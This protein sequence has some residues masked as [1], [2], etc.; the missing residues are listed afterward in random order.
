VKAS[1]A[2]RAT[3]SGS[4]AI[5]Y[6]NDSQPRI[7][8]GDGAGNIYAFDQTDAFPAPI[9]QAALGGPVDGPPI[10]AN[11]VV[12]AATDLE[13]GNPNLFALDQATG[14]VLFN[15]VL[16]GGIASEPI[17]ADGRLVIA[18]KSGEVVAYDGP[19]S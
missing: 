18:T 11:G 14:R 4:A 17:V 2:A 9:W 8:V 3:I 13:V 12:Y 1:F 16:P 7:F 5:G 15:A 10:L 19:D 6:P